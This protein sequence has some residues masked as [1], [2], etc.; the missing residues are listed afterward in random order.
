MLAQ[1]LG[2]TA[3]EF[4]PAATSGG[5]DTIRTLSPAFLGFQFVPAGGITID[6][7]RVYLD[8][9]S[10]PCVSASWMVPPPLL[11][12]KRFEEITVLCQEATDKVAA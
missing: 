11:R 3:V 2:L 10:V 1:S 8:L 9:P 5:P 7:I 12:A 6:T 4:F